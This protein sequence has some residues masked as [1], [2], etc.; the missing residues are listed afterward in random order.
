M[1]TFVGN[2]KTPEKHIGAKQQSDV[3][4]EAREKQGRLVRNRSVVAAT[5]D[6][7]HLMTSNPPDLSAPVRTLS[8]MSEGLGLIGFTNLSDQSG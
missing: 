4:T 7:S 2:L 1:K 8:L 5:L 6:R 3:C